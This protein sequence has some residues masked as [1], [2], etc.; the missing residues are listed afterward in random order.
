VRSC[1]GVSP[2]SLIY[3]PSLNNAVTRFRHQILLDRIEE[4]NKESN[5]PAVFYITRDG[6]ELVDD[7]YGFFPGTMAPWHIEH[8]LNFLEAN[9]RVRVF[10]ADPESSEKIAAVVSDL[11]SVIMH[12]ENAPV[13]AANSEE[14]PSKTGTRQ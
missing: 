13:S 2:K 6:L 12:S 10:K 14:G 11:V 7:P 9:G 5:R 3:N 4:V 8:S 1:F